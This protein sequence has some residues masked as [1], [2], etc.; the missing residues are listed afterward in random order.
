MSDGLGAGEIVDVFGL[1]DKD[2]PEISVLSDEF[3]DSITQKTGQENVQRKLLQKLLD[4]Q[5]K[6]RRRTNNLQA[7]RFSDEIEA[8]LRRYE[9]RQLTSQE[10][11]ERLIDIAKRLRDA[12][13]RH[14]A[15]GLTEEEAAFY[16]AL[17]G[18]I[19]HVKADPKLAAI[20]HELVESIRKDLSVDWT[21]R[22][23]SEARVRTKI[24]RLLRKHKGD[25]PAPAAAPSTNGG[26]GGAAGGDGA[27]VDPIN[28]FTQLVLD[29]AKSLYRYWPEVGDRLFAEIS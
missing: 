18:G 8:V 14:E 20:A 17:A 11:V 23:A 19:E 5:L 9:L 13:H 29:Q 25:L 27:S 15:L 3:L 22:A 21:D 1:A 6:A 24:K 10:V 26:G 4:D 7:K 16:D 12:G 2:R 28:Y